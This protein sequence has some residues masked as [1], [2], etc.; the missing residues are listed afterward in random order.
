M[1]T[2]DGVELAVQVHG[3]EDAPP[4]LFLH[5]FG[6]DHRSWVPQV[7]H[8]ADRYRCVTY[9]ARGYPPSA[10]PTDPAA[11]SQDHAVADAV[12]VLDGLGIERAVVV[13]NSMGGF[14]TLHL[15][16][17]HPGRCVALVVAGCGY[18]APPE[19][20]EAFRADALA[21]ADAYLRDGSAAVAADYGNRASRQPLRRRD[22]AAHDEHLRILA[23]HDPTGAALTMRGVQAARPSIYT[24]R[25]QLATM[26]VPTLLVVGDT[27]RD[28]LDA[29]LMLAATLPDAGLAVLPRTGHLTNLE[30][31]EVFNRLVADV[32]PSA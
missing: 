17:R 15:G 3:P 14:A 6:G 18:G 4:I 8:F 12:A 10:V 9:D 25:D 13:G 5:E 26:T 23:E 20:T 30:L 19:Q 27:D 31:P 7:A 28:A 16:L 32:L 1:I 11:Y 21:L 29:N 22:P 24:L 2:P